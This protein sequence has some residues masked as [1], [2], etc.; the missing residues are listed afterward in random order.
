M[1]PNWIINDFGAA[2]ARLQ[3]A[4]GSN[5]QGDLAHA[6][7][8]QYF[9]FTFEIAWKSVKLVALE[10]GLDAVGS[11]KACLRTALAQGWIDD[12]AVWL[13]M[14]DARNRMSHTYNA[15]G[16]LR[17]YDELGDFI[18]PLADLLVRL[19]VALKP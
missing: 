19:R 7:C 5:P 14:L 4:V 15:T 2:L 16:A 9:E 8:I 6:G 18:A 10:Q 11:P 12:E 3:E 17:V 13:R 1:N